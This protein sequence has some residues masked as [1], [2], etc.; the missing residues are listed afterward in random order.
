MTLENVKIWIG[1]HYG[2]WLKSRASWLLVGIWCLMC[3]VLANAYAGTLFSFVSVSKLEPI[4]NSLEDLANA[5]HLQFLI[6]DRT[7]IAIRLLVI[8]SYSKICKLHS[9]FKMCIKLWHERL[10]L[11][12]W[13][14][15]LAILCEPTLIIW[16]KI[17]NKSR[18]NW[19]LVA[20]FSLL[21]KNDNW[22][23]KE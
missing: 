12:E 14:K 21:Y 7:E 15:W 20:T 8:D 5:K 3:V 18:I 11:A 1:Y 9:S 23:K 2:L 13:R 19:P 4:V 6:Q 16:F 17:W 22:M 10:Q